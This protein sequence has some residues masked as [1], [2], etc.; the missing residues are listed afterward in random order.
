MGASTP[1]AANEPHDGSY[2]QDRP[3]MSS[4]G[5]SPFRAMR[6]SPNSLSATLPLPVPPATTPRVPGA[7]APARLSCPRITR[8]CHEPAKV[9]GSDGRVRLRGVQSSSDINRH[10]KD[11]DPHSRKAWEIRQAHKRTQT[12]QHT[13]NAASVWHA[14]H[15]WQKSEK[16]LNSWYSATRR[17]AVADPL[18][19]LSNRASE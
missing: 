17:D 1:L 13:A 9:L 7:L 19:S 15:D 5:H 4:Q 2:T 8:G 14:L 6:T 3:S 16:P 18:R 11:V 12:L 10:L